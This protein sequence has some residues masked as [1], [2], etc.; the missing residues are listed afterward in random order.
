MSLPSHYDT[1]L[2]A[3][4][5]SGKTFAELAEEVGKPEV[6][7]AALFFGNAVTDAETAA[8]IAS[9]IGCSDE[10]AIGAMAGR[11][12]GNVGVSGGIT[13]GRG[14]EWPPRD[15]VLYRFAEAVMVYGEAWKALIHEK[16][17]CVKTGLTAVGDGIM[18]AITFRSE[19]KRVPDPSGDRVLITLDGKVRQRRMG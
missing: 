19:L 18:S 12:A 13:R 9:A 5:A 1:L 4:T 10:A 6:W 17:E 3:K 15:P 16:C 14:W 7:L 11:G 2:A 8:R